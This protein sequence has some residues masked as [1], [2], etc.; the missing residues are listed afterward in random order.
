MHLRKIS[1]SQLQAICHCLIFFWQIMKWPDILK[2][3]KN[4]LNISWAEYCSPSGN[5]WKWK[6]SQYTIMGTINIINLLFRRNYLLISPAASTTEADIYP[7]SRSIAGSSSTCCSSSVASP[8]LY[9]TLVIMRRELTSVCVCLDPVS[10]IR[11]QT[12]STSLY[13]LTICNHSNSCCLAHS[14][15]TSMILSNTF[16]DPNILSWFT[17][18]FSRLVNISIC[19][20]NISHN[21]HLSSKWNSLSFASVLMIL[22]LLAGWFIES[23]SHVWWLCCV[24]CVASCN[25]NCAIVVCEDLLTNIL[26]STKHCW[27]WLW[28]S[29]RN[30]R[31]DQVNHIITYIYTVALNLF[32]SL[33]PRNIP[34]EWSSVLFI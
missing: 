16:S 27:K 21:S 3:W 26:E 32:V 8:L 22:L 7:L 2:N 18:G 33:K 12:A 6:C 4:I 9:I 29:K 13:C 14:P 31:M 20:V 34:N 23:L 10:N 30:T 25:K 28:K 17:L 11:V 1:S 24:E 19:L 15:F 5:L